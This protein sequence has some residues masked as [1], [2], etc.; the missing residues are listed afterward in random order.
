M[1]YLQLL[2]E[3]EQRGWVWREDFLYAPH[4]S[5]WFFRQGA[6]WESQLSRGG[7]FRERMEGRRDR[8]VGSHDEGWE[9]VVAD[10]QS[11]VDAVA[12]L[13][14]SWGDA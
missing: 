9:L 4:G 8:I 7:G 11:V 6:Q 2:S 14:K 3:L 12:A 10:V 1:R 13:E 5:M